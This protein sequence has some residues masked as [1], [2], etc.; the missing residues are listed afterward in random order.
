[1]GGGGG[2]GGGRGNDTSRPAPTP[3]VGASLHLSRTEQPPITAPGRGRRAK[4]KDE[5][6]RLAA[7]ASNG[8]LTPPRSAPTSPA[9]LPRWPL[10]LA[11]ETRIAP[12]R[13]GAPRAPARV[14][15]KSRVWAGSVAARAASDG[16]PAQGRRPPRVPIA[17]QV[18]IET[19][20]LRRHVVDGDM[21]GGETSVDY[22]GRCGA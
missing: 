1:L 20:E 16:R 4:G 13:R 18:K 3:S 14:N 9:R 12:P 6:P 19:A 5:V 15:P 7:P 11:P 8:P 21:R 10:H 2:G 17:R 22:S